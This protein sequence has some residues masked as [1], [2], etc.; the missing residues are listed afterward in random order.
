MTKDEI[1]SMLASIGVERYA[2]RPKTW[3]GHVEVF[4]RFAA[5]VAAKEREEC[6]QVAA[7]T[8]FGNAGEVNHEIAAAI[9]ARGE[10]A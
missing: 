1:V 5:V 10:Q 6:A 9:R 4:E 8:Y 3:D 7:D 2:V